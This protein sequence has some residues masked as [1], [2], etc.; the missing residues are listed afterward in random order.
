MKTVPLNKVALKK[1]TINSQIEKSE[2]YYE[3]RYLIGFI[4]DFIHYS[5]LWQKIDFSKIQS[6]TGDPANVEVSAYLM[7]KIK[8]ESLV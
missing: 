7:Y 5:T 3:G 4:N 2:I 6:K 1:S 8:P